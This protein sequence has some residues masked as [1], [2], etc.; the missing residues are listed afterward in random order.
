MLKN[1]N[2]INPSFFT[3]GMLSI[4]FFTVLGVS[5][6]HLHS[7]WLITNEIFLA[8]I[9]SIIIPIA[10]LAALLSSFILKK[11]NKKD[12]YSKIFFILLFFFEIF[13]N[14]YYSFITIDMS[15]DFYIK[16]YDL[17]NNIININVN[18]IDIQRQNEMIVDLDVKQNMRFK[19]ILSI[20]TGG[21]IPLVHFI[22][23]MI[24]NQ[25]IDIYYNL[26][27]KSEEKSIDNDKKVDNIENEETLVNNDNS[28][29]EIN[30]NIIEEEEKNLNNINEDIIIEEVLVKNVIDKNKENNEINQDKQ[31]NV[32]E[33]V[34]LDETKLK[35]T[36]NKE[37]KK[38]W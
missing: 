27:D 29:E 36:K 19:A 22:C 17:Y 7:F 32:I 30:E 14:I 8:R 24:L 13:G 38:L 28:G 1:I 37:I 3:I 25:I 35:K 31:K 11:N 21:F 2:I 18:Y 26:I 20:I 4:V 34:V 33:N 10:T 12:N 16:L 15:S 9:I 5:I 23:L 6:Y